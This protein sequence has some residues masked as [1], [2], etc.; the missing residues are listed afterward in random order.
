MSGTGVKDQVLAGTG[1]R[2]QY[3]CYFTSVHQSIPTS[4]SILFLSSTVCQSS[5]GISMDEVF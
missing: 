2:D 5:V 1:G 3:T 4:L